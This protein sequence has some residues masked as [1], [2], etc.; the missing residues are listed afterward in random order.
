MN[1]VILKCRIWL[2]IKTI[3]HVIFLQLT[4]YIWNVNAFFNLNKHGDYEKE[5]R[6]LDSI[7]KPKLSLLTYFLTR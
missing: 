3:C 1:L 6:F 2:I 5:R 7:M 4:V